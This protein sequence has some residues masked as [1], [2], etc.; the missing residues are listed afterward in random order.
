MR[1]MPELGGHDLLREWQAAMRSLAGHAEVPRQLLAP[2]QR[3]AELVQ[4]ILEREG[5]LQRDVVN[6][7]LGP[8]DAI[9]DLLEQS[10]AALHQQAVALVEAGRA[11]EQ[12]AALVK[13][14]ADLFERTVRTIRKPTEMAR[15]AGGE[16]RA[17]RAKRP[18]S[19]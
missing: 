19:T 17:P 3:Q 9:F 1:Q 15:A 13:A 7:L 14:Q 16:R 8:A 18:R 10:G 5:R 6:R 2:M 12:T 11:L 4:E